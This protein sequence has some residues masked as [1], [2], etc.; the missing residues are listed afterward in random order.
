VETR[1]TLRTNIAVEMGRQPSATF[2]QGAP[3]PVQPQLVLE[4]PKS[5]GDG[6]VTATELLNALFQFIPNHGK[7]H[8]EEVL[9]KASAHLGLPLKK[10][11]SDFNRLIGTRSARAV[12]N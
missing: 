4:V 5:I 10:A 1:D 9:E 8:R 6:L 12:W 7:I 3:S 2:K 11:H